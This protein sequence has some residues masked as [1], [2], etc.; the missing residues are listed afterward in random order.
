MSDLGLVLWLR[1]RHAWSRLVFWGYAA[2][3]DLEAERGWLARLYVVYLV[4]LL[5]AWALAMYAAI[6]SAVSDYFVEPSSADTQIIVGLA[7]L[8]PFVATA[9]A[10]VSALRSSP[11]KFS[12]PDSAFLGASP[13]S[14][15]VLFGTEAVSR[16]FTAGSAA[17][18]GGYVFGV[19]LSSAGTGADPFAC[20]IVV[21]LAAT[22]V[23]LSGWAAGVARLAVPARWRPALWTLVGA[24]LV[25]PALGISNGVISARLVAMLGLASA[26][27]HATG[28]IIV[29]AA[30]VV[31]EM[32]V[33]LAVSPMADVTMAMEESGLYAEL[34]P[35]RLLR[36]FDPGAYSEIARSK[37]L[38]RSAPK[39]GV[40]IG[41]GGF[42]PLSRAL[43]SYLR[44]PGRLT[45]LLVWGGLV[46]PTGVLLVL[47]AVNPIAFVVWIT[48]A[49][50][51]SSS[52]L[53]R[54]FRDDL[55]RPMLRSLL[56]FDTLGLL[57]LDSLPAALLAT[58][59]S[60]AV[61]VVAYGP[62]RGLL[63][64]LILAVLLNALA[65]LYR[66]LEM[67]EHPWIGRVI[68]YE[69]SML[70]ILGLVAVSSLDHN[71][72]WPTMIALLGA[73]AA[74]TGIRTVRE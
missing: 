2:A 55:G 3:V 39:K 19:G 42:A 6:T 58:T 21:A 53:A 27:S 40:L 59:A 60:I 10:L 67:F 17:A 38:A 70:V 52:E 73:A 9:L 29:L 28:V 24:P 20:A 64:G 43:T 63:A 68:H 71:P 37:R 47:W 18:F 11:L 22:G 36:R 14:S 51:G 15:R 69:T 54:V 46:V 34:Q 57:L 50:M 13:I 25:L 74:V 61:V 35:L 32:L 30:V 31:L 23:V 49:L 26:D 48:T 12:A 66:G 65:L 16:A 7:I 8:A 56:P 5:G 72:W 4:V 44:Q 33:L 1:R 45:N 41:R 62:G